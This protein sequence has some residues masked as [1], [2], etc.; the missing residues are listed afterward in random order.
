MLS[1]VGAAL[2]DVGAGVGARVM[3]DSVLATL[4]SV[5]SV[6]CMWFLRAYDL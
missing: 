3:Q 2:A 4:A 5:T 1:A 6:A